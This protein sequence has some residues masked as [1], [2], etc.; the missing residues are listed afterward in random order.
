MSSTFTLI[1]KGMLAAFADRWAVIRPTWDFSKQT[2]YPPYDFSEPQ[3]LWI[4]IIVTNQGG[5]NEAIGFL[6]QVSNLLTV[7]CYAPFNGDDLTTMFSVDPLADDVHNALRSMTMP[8][9]VDDFDI[10]PRDFPVTPT[11]FEHKRLSLLFDFY[12]PGVS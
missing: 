11:G 3:D 8:E 5:S 4:K 6:D 2:A 10:V 12:L 9:G 1:R 7:D